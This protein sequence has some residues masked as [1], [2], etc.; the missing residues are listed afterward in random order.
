M[1]AL[2]LTKVY[3]Q[4]DPDSPPTYITSI[5]SSGIEPRGL[6]PSPDNSRMYIVNEHSDTV[7]FVDLS[8]MSIAKTVNV[9][10]EGQALVYVANAV[11]TGNGTQNLGRQGLFEKPASNKLVDVLDSHGSNGSALATVRPQNGLDMFQL[12]GRNLRLNTTY[13]AFAACLQC[14]GTKI[15]LVDFMATAPTQAGCGSA[16]QVLAFFKFRAFMTWTPWRSAEQ[17]SLDLGGNTES[18]ICT[19]AIQGGS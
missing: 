6:W 16:P 11:P 2:N 9:G 15:P 14:N 7:D 13:T 12:I 4:R 10:Q 5:T 3:A 19:S 18:G 8:S 17:F 1:A